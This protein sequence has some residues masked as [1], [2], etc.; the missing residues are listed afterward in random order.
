MA[1]LPPYRP[2]LRLAFGVCHPALLCESV[3]GDTHGDY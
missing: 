1:G 3:Y 2:C